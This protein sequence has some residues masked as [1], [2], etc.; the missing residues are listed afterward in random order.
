MSAAV[1]A[2]VAQLSAQRLAWVEIDPATDSRPARR[3]QIDTPSQFRAARMSDVFRHDGDALIVEL[4]PLVKAWEGLTE[5]DLLGAGVGSDSPA[6]V[7]PRVVRLVLA[8]RPRWAQLICVRAIELARDVHDRL[9][10]DTG[11]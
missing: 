5:A 1:D 8:D 9:K 3:V 2:L 6:P 11:N 7:D 4:L 10:A